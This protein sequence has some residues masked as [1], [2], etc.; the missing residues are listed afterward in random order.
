MREGKGRVITSA[1][2]FGFGPV[3][4]LR[5][6]GRLLDGAGWELDF[7]GAASAFTYA[8]GETEIFRTVTETRDPDDLLSVDAAGYD[9]ALSVMDPFLAVW[10]AH[11][12][13]PCLYVDSLFWFWGWPDQ[14]SLR[15]DWDAVMAPGA[16]AAGKLD[17]LRRLP[18]P[19]AEYVGHRAA[20]VSCVQRTPSTPA[21]CD[22]MRDIARVVP[23]GA[24]VDLSRRR[25][26]PAD[27]WM[28]SLSGLVNPLITAKEAALWAGA[29]IRLVDEAFTAA[30]IP[31]ATVRLTGNADVIGGLEGI[32][33]RFAFEARNA[34]ATL[35]LFNHAHACLAP[36]GLTT[37]LESLA[38]ECPV[39]PLP[40]QH[41]G[42]ER[43]L[44]EFSDHRADAFPQSVTTGMLDVEATGDP[45]LDTQ[46]VIEAFHGQ[47]QAGGNTWREMVASMAA[48][49]CSVQ[50]DPV[51]TLDRQR[52]V[53]GNFVGGFAGAREVVRTFDAMVAAAD[54]AADSP[55]DSGAA[56][57][58]RTVG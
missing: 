43:I 42:H 39:I 8:R 36:P 21:T 24:I 2:P 4:K 23:T 25:E 41:Y 58:R 46:R 33:E 16:T 29:A 37:M 6:V 1:E 3:S 50:R 57:E 49:L 9:A 53:V 44:A 51:A 31:G 28:M 32:P 20:S 30:D 22:A 40:P 45:A 15:R 48:T 11:H 26:A 5:S 14:E 54:T 55:A 7:I 47:A 56:A 19:A 27:I 10:A 12:G 18:M 35:D 38:Y 13:L 52:S 34:G 17:L